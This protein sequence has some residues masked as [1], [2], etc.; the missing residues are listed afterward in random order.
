MSILKGNCMSVLR[1]RVCYCGLDGMSIVQYG[2]SVVL[3][4][5]TSMFY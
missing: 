5:I 2:V 3:N 1:L 4:S